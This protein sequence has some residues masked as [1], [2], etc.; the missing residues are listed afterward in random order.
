M[1]NF[2]GFVV[3]RRRPVPH[4]LA[5]A[6]VGQRVGVVE[7]GGALSALVMIQ[8]GDHGAV[9]M[10]GQRREGPDELRQGLGLDLHLPFR[11]VDD[12]PEA[13]LAAQLEDVLELRIHGLALVLGQ[14]KPGLEQR[15][16]LGLLQGGE[17]QIAEQASFRE[18]PRQQG[19]REL[20]E[21]ALG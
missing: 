21:K 17:V 5:L 1:N 18:I 7:A 2:C 14:R 19:V 6:P 20:P 4:V 16:R 10:V 3:H 13:L 11:L 12:G 8:V 9:V 15:V